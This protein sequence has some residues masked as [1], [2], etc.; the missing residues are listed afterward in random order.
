MST[1]LRVDDLFAGYSE[2]DI[3]KGLSLELRAGELVTV[4]GPN[5]A[6]KSTVLKAIMGLLKVRRGSITLNGTD[7]T[8][9]P[10]E[11]LSSR[12][13][14]YVPQVDNVFRNLTVWENLAVGQPRRVLQQRLPNIYEHFP[15]LRDRRSVKAGS[16]SGGERQMLALG[17]ALMSEPSVILLDEPTAALAPKLVN[18]ILEHI[19]SVTK[20]GTAV[21]LVEQNARQSLTFSDRAYVLDDGRTALSGPAADVLANP[22]VGRL[23]L[24]IKKD[25]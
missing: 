15:V 17:L 18:L 20:R 25:G 21:L 12:G 3:L 11:E 13:V 16:L 9:V 8:T 23:Y 4:I 7:L 14:A 5:G 1:H 19:Q 2:A 22:D 6:G 24:G 10:T